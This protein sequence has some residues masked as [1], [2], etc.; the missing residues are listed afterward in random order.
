MVNYYLFYEQKNFFFISFFHDTQ[1]WAGT[2]LLIIFTQG[3]AGPVLNYLPPLSA[4]VFKPTGDVSK[5]CFLK[6]RFL[7]LYHFVESE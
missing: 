6:L 2:I 5:M 4:D 1:I 7:K 3:P